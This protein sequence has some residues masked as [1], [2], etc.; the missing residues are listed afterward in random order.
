MDWRF[1]VYCNGLDEHYIDLACP[2]GKTNSCLEFCPMVALFA[3]SVAS[4]YTVLFNSTPSLGTHVDDIFGGFKGCNDYVKACHFR[5]FLCYVGTALTINFNPKPEKTPMPATIQVILGRRYD[6]SS[7]RVNT[8]EKKVRKYR[9]RIASALVMN[10]ISR[11]DVER[12]HGVLNYVAE[13]EPFGRPFLSQLTVVISG[14][15]EGDMVRLPV[16]A[17]LGLKI[18]DSILRRNKGSSF[19]FVLDRLP[20]SRSNIFVDASSI[21]G[22]GGCVG[23]DYFLIP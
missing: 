19:D 1:Q 14:V 7:K 16:L 23:E 10:E 11:K 8:S 6:S 22:I 20:L 17:K 5:D 9:L 12:L 21:W 15:K 2:L 18:W 13:V 4:K 3:K